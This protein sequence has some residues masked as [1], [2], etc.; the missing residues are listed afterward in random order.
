VLLTEMGYTTR[1]DPALRPWEWPDGM[2]NVVV[3][4]P[5]QATAYRALLAPLLDEPWCAG[6]FVWRTYADPGDVSQE[7]EWGFSPTG[8]LAELVVRDAFAASWAG[9]GNGLWAS[10]AGFRFDGRI[11]RRSTQRARTPGVLG[12]E[13]S[14]PPSALIRGGR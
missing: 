12:W 2:S 3:D 9:D 13:L 11:P 8:K 7:A 4:Q 6:F 14:P 1:P 10:W 5:A